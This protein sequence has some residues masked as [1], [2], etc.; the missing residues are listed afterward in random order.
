MKNK[1]KKISWDL[2]PLLMVTAALPLV[3]MGRKVSVSLEKYS[4]F[5]DGNYQYDFFMYAKSIVF[6]ILVAWML[7][8]LIDRGLIRGIKL[9][10]W[11]LFI[12][13]YI[14]GL[15]ALISTVFSADRELSLKGMWQQYES[16]WILLGYLIT[17][18][19]CV[20]VVQSL[21]DIRILCI[22]VAVGAAV[23]GILGISQF[24][25][26]D[27]FASEIGRNFLALG[28]D[29]S[30]SRTIR[31]VYEGNS[32]SSVYMAS[33]T[34]NY[35]G[36]YLVMVLPVLFVLA[37]Q[38]KKI[39]YKIL[40]TCLI[41]ILLV[42]LY[43]TGSKA[44]FLVCGFLAV[45][46]IILM[47]QKH[48]TKKKWIYVGICILAAAGITAGYDQFSGHA[49]SD[50][51]QQI[52]QKET[53][54]LEEIKSESDGVC[55]KYRGNFLKLIPEENEMGQ[56][57]TAQINKKEKQTAFWDGESQ[58]FIFNDKSFGSLKFDTYREKGTQYLIIYDGD[59][60]WNFYKEDGAA[61]YVFVNQYGKLDEIQNAAA[62]F[63]GHERSLS[64]RGYIWGRTIPLLKKFL[65]W[66][67]GPDTFT[68]KFPQ[69][70]YVMKVNTGLNM[71][72]QLPT[73]AHSMYLQSALQTGILSGICL[74]MFFLHYIRIAVR[75]AK[76]EKNREKAMFRTGILLSVIGFLLMG[77]ANDSNLAVSPLF[78][79][80]L[81]MGI[82]METETFHS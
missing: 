43:G 64:G 74:L 22:S 44:G 33:Y 49:L 48:H 5:A 73:K 60:T 30:I 76:T 71:Y 47:A 19:Y 27:L 12:P 77:L 56:T 79:C 28:M 55:L 1:T 69:T 54:D 3:A 32:R 41:G 82:A 25:G 13:L 9:K 2:L 20:Q 42:C 70:D 62:V 37:L 39:G 11:K 50:A 57:L 36:M 67:S 66:G 31:F 81:G 24:I 4:W 78:W 53:Y 51:L 45:L 26:R 75:N 21:Q 14:Y 65:L 29:S 34:P 38:A 68:V 10:H 6:L 80:I 58:S 40:W 59:M 35:A 72:Q 7:I 63:K 23:Q 8:V 18:F 16:V 52:V 17:A 46:V 61:R 15:M